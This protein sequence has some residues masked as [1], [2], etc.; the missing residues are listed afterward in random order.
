MQ[1]NVQISVFCLFDSKDIVFSSWA[2]FD[3]YNTFCFC[4][5]VVTLVIIDNNSQ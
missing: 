3:Y 5:L 1:F 4:K 2:V